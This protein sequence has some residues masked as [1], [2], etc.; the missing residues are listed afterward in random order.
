[1]GSILQVMARRMA[2]IYG[3]SGDELPNAVQRQFRHT[4]ESISEQLPDPAVGV[5]IHVLA[6]G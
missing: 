5:E 1:M 3:F 2:G 6:A 4:G